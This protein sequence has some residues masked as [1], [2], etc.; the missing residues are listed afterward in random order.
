MLRVLNAA[1][2]PIL[3]WRI[4]SLE[5]SNPYS[6]ATITGFKPDKRANARLQ[7]SADEEVITLP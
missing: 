2:M 5:E 3:Y 4:R 7:R 6:L 1:D